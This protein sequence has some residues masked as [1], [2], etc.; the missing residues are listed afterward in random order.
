MHFI[1]CEKT[2]KSPAKLLKKQEGCQEKTHIYVG[3][4]GTLGTI[5]IIN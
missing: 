1:I 4:L 3:T 5:L 2:V